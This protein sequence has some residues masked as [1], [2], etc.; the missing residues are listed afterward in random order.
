MTEEWIITPGTT[1]MH[2]FSI[3]ID[4]ELLKKVRVIYT[5]RRS[6]V[7]R[8][9]GSE[10][11]IGEGMITVKLTQEE[12]LRFREEDE[13]EIVLRALTKGGDAL[14]SGPWTAKVDR[15][16]DRVVLE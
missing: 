3:S 10:V 14:I 16:Y 7:V 6:S 5:Q 9:E 1:P 13:V 4:S 11:E 2:T 12:T 15:C 8:K